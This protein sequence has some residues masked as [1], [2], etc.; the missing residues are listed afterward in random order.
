M[1]PICKKRFLE[2]MTKFKSLDRT[3]FNRF[4]KSYKF[5]LKYFIKLSTS[6]INKSILDSI[7][8]DNS[9]IDL[10]YLKPNKND[11]DDYKYHYTVI[12]NCNRLLSIENVYVYKDLFDYK[13]FL[14]DYF[15]D[16]DNKSEF[17][18]FL[19]CNQKLHKIKFAPILFEL[20]KVYYHPKNINKWIHDLD[21]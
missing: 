21:D 17:E 12:T 6:F 7:I 4:Y 18:W 10:N 20:I 15:S 1:Y 19:S 9:D 13:K 5:I 2:I 3:K 11:F 14:S 8:N 16:D